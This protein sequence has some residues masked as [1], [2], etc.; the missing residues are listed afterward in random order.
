MGGWSGLGSD[1][2]LTYVAIFIVFPSFPSEDMLYTGRLSFCQGIL[3]LLLRPLLTHIFSPPKHKALDRRASVKTPE[4]VI[5]TTTAQILSVLLAA[6]HVIP[7]P[8]PTFGHRDE[9]RSR[10]EL[11]RSR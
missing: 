6:D 1:A 11:W 10:F 7:S 3:P 4:H 8:P 5:A 9:R 2:V